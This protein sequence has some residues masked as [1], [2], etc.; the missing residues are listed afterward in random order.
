MFKKVSEKSTHLASIASSCLNMFIKMFKM[1][2]SKAITWKS[3]FSLNSMAFPGLTL[4]R[5]SNPYQEYEWLVLPNN[6]TYPCS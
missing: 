6:A 4:S 3:S 2:P 1:P 5:Q